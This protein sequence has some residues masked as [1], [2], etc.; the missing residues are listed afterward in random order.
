MKTLKYK[1]S[2]FKVKIAPTGAG[3]DPS[4]WVQVVEASFGN[5]FWGLLGLENLVFAEAVV[6][7]PGET[8]EELVHRAKAVAAAQIDQRIDLEVGLRCPRAR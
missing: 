2:G 3:A 6:R 7:K 4:L 8:G 5:W 1:S